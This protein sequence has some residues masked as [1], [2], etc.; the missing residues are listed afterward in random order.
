M[1]YN[2]LLIGSPVAGRHLVR[3]HAAQ[4]LGPRTRVGA[5]RLAEAVH[6][7][8]HHLGRVRIGASRCIAALPHMHHLNTAHRGGERERERGR[9]NCCL[10]YCLVYSLHHRCLRRLVAIPILT[11]PIDLAT[12]GTLNDIALPHIFGKARPGGV[13]L[14]LC[15]Y[16]D[17]HLLAIVIARLAQIQLV[18]VLV[19]I[20][21]DLRI[22]MRLTIADVSHGTL[23]ASTAR[24]T[25]GIAG[26]I[27]VWKRIDCLLNNLASKF[28]IQ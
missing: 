26:E 7:V 2:D 11:R 18:L 20:V 6:A 10:K 13:R 1:T 21:A 28:L 22:E 19:L 12:V 5:Y 27:L 23:T 4:S 3:Q 25:V 8:Q 16:A 9:L 14:G 24:L 17:H 15:A